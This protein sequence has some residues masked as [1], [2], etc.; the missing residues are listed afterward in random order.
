[1]GRS[2]QLTEFEEF[3]TNVRTGKT[4]TRGFLISGKSGIGKSS[5]ALKARYLFQRDRVIFL[6]IDSRL[7]DDVSFLFDAINELLFE[8]RQVPE[9]NA[10][11]SD[12]R[13]QGL[14]SLIVT[15]ADINKTIS[16]ASYLAVLFFDQFEKVFEYPDV[17]SAIRTLFLNVTEKQLPILFGFAWKSDL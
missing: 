16:K 4:S 14:D 8:L 1:V 2:I 13:V 11:L 5:L 7:C 6:P 12:T 10:D 17:T 3:V 15:L 9:L